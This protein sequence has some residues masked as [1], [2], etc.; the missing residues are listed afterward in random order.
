MMGGAR[1]REGLGR[2]Q[3]EA[4]PAGL[5]GDGGLEAE[6]AGGGLGGTYNIGSSGG[7]S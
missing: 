3:D 6:S 5:E 2:S 7:R 1:W 4:G